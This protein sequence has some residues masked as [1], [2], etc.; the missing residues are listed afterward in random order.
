M[1][2]ALWLLDAMGLGL[3]TVTGIQNGLDCQ[4]AAGS[5]V[6]LGTVTACLGG[7]IRD[8]LLNKVPL[9][10]QKEVYAS[11]SIA[12]VVLFLLLQ[13]SV[14]CRYC[15]HQQPAFDC[16]CAPPGHPL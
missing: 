13:R 14:G 4:L 7:V 3:F 10:L 5:C 1:A 16:H 6:A 11:A 9:I 15:K 12:A 8:V 2:T